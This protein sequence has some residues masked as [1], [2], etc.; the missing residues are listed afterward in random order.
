M[1]DFPRAQIALGGFCTAGLSLGIGGLDG[2]LEKG[3]FALLAL[4][5][6]YQGYRMYP[7]TFLA[8]KQVL[9]SIRHRPDSSFSL[10]I[11][12]V[13]RENRNV[14]KYLEIVR[15]A[16][17]DILLAAETDQWWTTQLG[18]LD[19]EYPYTVKYPLDN[20]YG[21]LLCSRLKLVDPDLKFLVED[22]IPSIHTGVELKS[23]DCFRLHCL[24][25]RPPHPPTDQDATERDAELLIVGRAVKETDEPALVAGDLNDVAWSDTTTLFQKISG[26]LDP[27]I[28]R[29]MYN[30][31]NANNPLFRWPLDH[32]FHSNHFK[33]L[34]LKRL[35]SF[36][37]DHFP[38]YIE[39]SY[40]PEAQ[41]QQPEPIADHE[42]RVEAEE[43]IEKVEQK[44]PV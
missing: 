2:G 43:K 32:V 21:I 25:P 6:L 33:L 22:D 9:A 18:Q 15:A 31:F 17:P 16:D 23:G 30:T 26:L 35:S 41:A 40:E 44:E 11:S 28:G 34:T 3:G 8:S 12:N 4:C 24:H 39:L 29:G 1:F 7:Y 37:S 38:V 27:R 5:V 42:E 14:A 10:L 19:K 20:C 36:G 13:L